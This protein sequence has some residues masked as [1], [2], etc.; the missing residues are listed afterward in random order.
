MHAARTLVSDRP[1]RS[2]S[3]PH[4]RLVPSAGRLTPT[5][6]QAVEIGRD[7]AYRLGWDAGLSRATWA[8]RL[9]SRLTGIHGATALADQRLEK[10]R[11]FAAM[12]RRDDRRMHA[13][14]DELLVDGLSQGALHQ[15][16][17]LALA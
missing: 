1:T 15:A 4:L 5:E 17:A 11:L 13:V 16:I 10:L 6:R 9:I 14:A 8:K 3:Q 7:D 12:M 2:P